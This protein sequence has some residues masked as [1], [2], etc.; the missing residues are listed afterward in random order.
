[1]AVVV[2]FNVASGVDVHEG[3]RDI[4]IAV[5]SEV[6]WLETILIDSKVD[7]I[8]SKDRWLWITFTSGSVEDTVVRALVNHCAEASASFRVEIWSCWIGS[9]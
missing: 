1:L 6:A 9:T 5:K 2:T 3:A 7:W 4:S 8:S